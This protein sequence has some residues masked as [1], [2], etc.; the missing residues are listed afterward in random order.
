MRCL[1]CNKEL[2]D[3]ESTRKYHGTNKFIDLCQYCFNN[4]DLSFHYVDTNEQLFTVKDHYE[5]DNG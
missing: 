4:S 2:N 1:S 3:H 5:D